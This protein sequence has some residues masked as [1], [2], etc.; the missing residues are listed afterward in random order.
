MVVNSNWIC[1]PVTD[2]LFKTVVK[3]IANFNIGIGPWI[4]GGCVRKLWQDIEWRHEDI[5]IF[6]KDETQFDRFANKVKTKKSFAD[7]F[8]SVNML[9]DP[10]T[11]KTHFSIQHDTNNAKTYSVSVDGINGNNA[12]KVQAIRKFFPESAIALI[13]D[14]DWTICQFVSDG[15]HMW[16]TPEAIEGITN[17]HL[18]LSKTSTRGIKALRLIKYLAYGFEV[19]DDIVINMLNML[20]NTKFRD[21]VLEDDY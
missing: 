8:N 19:D 1:K 10:R 15:R 3:E 13:E 20:D 12:F 2:I 5:D 11:G 18:V 9:P 14:F 21:E 6:F 4:A 16:A 17:N 7:V